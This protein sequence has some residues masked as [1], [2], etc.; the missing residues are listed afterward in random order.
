M[1]KERLV[2]LFIVDIPSISFN[3]ATEITQAI[4]LYSLH[5]IKSSDLSKIAE[6]HGA[7]SQV[8]KFKKEFLDKT[9]YMISKFWRAIFAYA[10]GTMPSVIAQ[11]FKV[12]EID[13]WLVIGHLNPEQ[14][15]QIKAK[16]EIKS[17]VEYPKKTDKLVK[18]LQDYCNILARKLSFV[19]NNDHGIDLNDIKTEILISGITAMLHADWSSDNKYILN[20]A[21]KAMWN[22]TV[23]LI[24][25]HT[26]EKRSR[27]KRTVEG[28]KDRIAE[29]SVTTYSLDYDSLDDDY[30]LHKSIS[31]ESD[32]KDVESNAWLKKVIAGLP[33][34][35]AN[36][37]KIAAGERNEKFEQW[38]GI[39][40]I[41]RFRETTLIKQ[42]CKFFKVSL[43]EVQKVMHI[44][45]KVP[46][47]ALA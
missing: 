36:V 15:D 28:E 8:L 12:D 4:I 37:V 5:I 41:Q 47:C 35:I 10:K 42:A 2:E 30:T 46:Q 24:K 9:E 3:G 44:F 1:L 21:K 23:S 6:K 43:K 33:Q 45:L 34:G 38:V 11:K 16:S 17:Y 31:D 22:S 27:L 32:Y 14:L 20:Y 40:K 25:F 18:T 26:A 13:I 19:I 29:Y 7:K 39:K